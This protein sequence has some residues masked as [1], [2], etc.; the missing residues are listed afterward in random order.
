MANSSKN[1]RSER[2]EVR[3]DDYIREQ[4]S[5]YQEQ[6]FKKDIKK[7]VNITLYSQVDCPVC[8]IARKALD[9]LEDIYFPYVI[10]NEQLVGKINPPVMEGTIFS[11]MRLG[12]NS[13]AES[14][15]IAF[16]RAKIPVTVINGT[17]IHAVDKF[18][19]KIKNASFKDI[20]IIMSKLT[21]EEREKITDGY[22]DGLDFQK[23]IHDEFIFPE[24]GIAS[25]FYMKLEDKIH[26]R[27]MLYNTLTN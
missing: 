7:T 27:D 19:L 2:G 8:R 24:T 12:Y 4:L 3:P 13:L 18:E 6:I 10:I 9:E 21:N 22:Y 23:F 25:N 16:H 15:N 14:I 5:E 11:V 17:D 1:P 26:E 20:N